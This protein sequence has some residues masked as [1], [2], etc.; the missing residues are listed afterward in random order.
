M[1]FNKIKTVSYT[2]INLF[3]ALALGLDRKAISSR[4]QRELFEVI[5]NESQCEAIC[6]RIEELL[7]IV[8]NETPSTDKGFIELDILSD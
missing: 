7:K 3:N 5:K 1:F 8:G 4:R 2:R 6:V